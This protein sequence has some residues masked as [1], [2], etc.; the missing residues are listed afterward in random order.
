MSIIF[1]KTKLKHQINYKNLE[2]LTR[3]TM[4]RDTIR[5]ELD[6]KFRFEKSLFCLVFFFC[7]CSL[8]IG[9]RENKLE[10]Y[11]ATTHLMLS[12]DLHDMYLGRIMKQLNIGKDS[13]ELQFRP[14]PHN[15]L[16]F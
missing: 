3:K 5:F 11:V 9:N 16:R 4:R 10:D 7:T 14:R 15:A 13:N 8:T 2:G 6:L 12:D 1:H